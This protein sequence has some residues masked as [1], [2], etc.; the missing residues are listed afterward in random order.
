MIEFNRE[1]T[2]MEGKFRMSG[3]K[4]AYTNVLSI[5]TRSCD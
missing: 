2:N 4:Q 1:L 5:W 3:A